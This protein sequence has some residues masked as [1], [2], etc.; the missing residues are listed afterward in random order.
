MRSSIRSEKQADVVEA[1]DLRIVSVA[2]WE[3][4]K[5]Q[6]A[7]LARA[8]TSQATAPALPFYSQQRPRYLLTG[9][10]TYGCCG[11]SYAKSGKSRF[12]CQDAAKKSPTWCDNRV[13]IRQDELDAR[14]L[15]G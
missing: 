7:K 4:V 10:M 6:Q 13:T 3:K 5:A 15:T 1:P 9:K 14:V 12:G 11:A 2:L 8:P